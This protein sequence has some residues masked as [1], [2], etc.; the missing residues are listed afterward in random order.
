MYV[1]CV[2]KHVSYGPPAGIVTDFVVPLQ[3]LTE[4]DLSKNHLHG[5]VPVPALGPSLRLLALNDNKLN[6]TI[7][8]LQNLTSLGSSITVL[9]FIFATHVSHL[10]DFYCISFPERL[11]LNHN[12]IQGHIPTSIGIMKSLA[13][14]RLHHNVSARIPLITSAAFFFLVSLHAVWH[15]GPFTRRQLLSG[16][17]PTEMEKLEALT[18]VYLEGNKLTGSV[19]S[20]NKSIASLGEYFQRSH[21]LFLY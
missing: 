1:H 9:L 21:L 14:L 16:P 10:S 19:P 6:G 4:L 12:K 13:E 5:S 3:S 2:S 18:K 8:D 11:D 7:A 20:F 15:P 17:I